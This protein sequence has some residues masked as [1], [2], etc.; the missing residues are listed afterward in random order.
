MYPIACVGGQQSFGV[1]RDVDGVGSNPRKAC[2]HDFVG[3]GDV[4]FPKL[5]GSPRMY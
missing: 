4:D 5:V 3:V 1:D 2:S